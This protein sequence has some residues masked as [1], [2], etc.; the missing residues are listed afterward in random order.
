MKPDKSVKVFGVLNAGTKRNFRL[1]HIWMDEN[2]YLP[3]GL[4]KTFYRSYLRDELHQKYGDRAFIW[5]EKKLFPI[6]NINSGEYDVRLMEFSICR[7]LELCLIKPDLFR[8]L[9]LQAQTIAKENNLTNYGLYVFDK[10]EEREILLVD[11]LQEMVDHH[12]I[13]T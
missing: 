11:L 6:V 13:E 7:I 3:R 1:F 4:K 8:N 5:P 12:T 10:E 9:L 2:N